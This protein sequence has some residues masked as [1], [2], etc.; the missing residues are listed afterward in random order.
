MFQ[1]KATEADSFNHS[2][3][4][5]KKATAFVVSVNGEEIGTVYTRSEE[6]MRM[7]GR[8]GTVCGLNRYWVARTP[9]GREDR[10]CNS[11]EVAAY[12]LLMMRA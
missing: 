4:D 6:R 12:A 7:N 9:A 8:I 10:M 5:T 1:F 11:R 3:G 2:Q